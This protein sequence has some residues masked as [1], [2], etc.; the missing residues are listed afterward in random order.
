MGSQTFDGLGRAIGT[1]DGGQVVGGR[2]LQCFEGN[3][4]ALLQ[5]A[6]TFAEQEVVHFRSFQVE[7]QGAGTAGARAGHHDA[8]FETIPSLQQIQN[9]VLQL[10]DHVALLGGGHRAGMREA[11]Q[12]D[13]VESMGRGCAHQHIAVAQVEHHFLPRQLKWSAHAQNPRQKLGKHATGHKAEVKQQGRSFLVPHTLG[14][15]FGQ[16]EAADTEARADGPRAKT[17]A[18]A[19]AGRCFAAGAAT[20]GTGR[21][22]ARKAV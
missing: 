12:N 16:A 22:A 11:E 21:T 6:A 10:I 20:D 9:A 5:P 18:K 4:N 17:A 14:V 15:D 3:A 19:Q 1:S 13:G 8:H 2:M 7:R